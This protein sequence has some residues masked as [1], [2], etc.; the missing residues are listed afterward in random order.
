MDV[1][2]QKNKPIHKF[3]KLAI[4]ALLGL[5]SFSTFAEVTLEKQI[6]IT[7]LALYFDGDKKS[8][9]QARNEP[10]VE[11]Q[12]YNFAYGRSI[13]P[14]GDA[15][16]VYKNF[17]FMTWYRGGLLD[18][19]VI[20][21][22]YN[23]ETGEQVDLEF[24]HQH[25]GFEGR[26][27]VGETHNTIAVGISP[28]DETIHLLYDM[29][30]Y[31]PGKDTG[32]N[33][34]FKHD[35]FRYSYSL[36][37][38]ATVA[39]DK[40]TLEQFV[41]DTSANNEGPDDYKHVT[42]TGTENA[43]AFGRLSYPKFFLNDQGDLFMDMRQGSSHDGSHVFNMYHPDEGK[44]GNF[45]RINVMGAGSKGDVKNWSIYGS[46]KFENGKM[47]IGF[48]RRMNIGGDKFYANEGMYYAYSDDPTGATE[49]KNYKGEPINMPIVAPD[50]VS[51]FDPS[52]LLP[53]ATGKDQVSITGGFHWAVTDNGDV[54]IVGRTSERVNNKNIRTIYSHHYQVGGKGEFITTTDFPGAQ[55]LYAA[56]EDIYIIGLENGR[57]FIEKAKGGTNDFTRLYH[58]PA[59][60]MI[61][62]KGRLH[63]YQ[64]KLYYYLLEKGTGDK[65]TTHLQIIDLDI[66]P[67][68]PDGYQYSTKE[69]QTVEISG[70][71][72]VAFG[73]DG[74]FTYLKNQTQNV[75]C[76]A[77]T[78][79]AAELDVEAA[80]FV[81]DVKP[82]IDFEEIDYLSE[83]YDTVTVK[84]NASAVAT[85]TVDNVALY[86]DENLVSVI[87][88]QPFTWTET[89]SQLMNLSVGAHTL[90]AVVT[91]NEGV[92]AEASGRLSVANGKPEVSLQQS[93]ASLTEGYQNLT[94]TASASSP[95]EDRS[96]KQVA[97]YLGTELVSV[98]NEAPYRW[99]Q[100]ETQL[101]ALTAGEY[102][103]IAEVI[104]DVG[105]MNEAE[106]QLTVAAGSVE[107]NNDNTPENSNTPDGD[108]NSGGGSS[109][110]I[111][112]AVLALVS[113]LRRLPSRQF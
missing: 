97:L 52:S 24:P 90:K 91:D 104:D 46:M 76:D 27:W 60:S 47:R 67:T 79:S 69:G 92:T 15:I 18:R 96:I 14:H 77:S 44:W 38:G 62:E 16:K 21:T 105:L 11:G 59:D 31:T 100:S 101:S 81:M 87:N 37:G 51:V 95:V 29:H 39:D 45:N 4:S 30:A 13:V 54:H 43:S 78:F 42:M 36:P 83:G 86:I 19:H 26:W 102:T 109:T 89:A 98:D 41:K 107:E 108:N 22:R 2:N 66:K 93:P 71:K 34:S 9:T 56:G 48:Q 20:L 75:S 28:K 7:D 10:Y 65:R 35:Y 57:P 25:T 73:A 70:V 99:T 110:G 103:F 61:F 72:D 8:V 5:T 53:D 64:G 63:I 1:N 74:N 94:L 50:E 85:R 68:G 17:V 82:S 23:M 32:G 6:K 40:F 3:K 33:G 55:G 58:A 84:V 113:A 49:W 12:K 80:C 111:L 106:L 112:F 88:S